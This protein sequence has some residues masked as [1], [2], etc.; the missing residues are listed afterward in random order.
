MESDTLFA[1]KTLNEETPP[2]DSPVAAEWCFGFDE[3]GEYRRE[4]LRG[5]VSDLS[6][7]GL[8]GID[9]TGDP[10]TVRLQ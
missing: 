1:S 5:L 2:V 3:D 9:E 8:V 7:D 4:W 6:D 10:V